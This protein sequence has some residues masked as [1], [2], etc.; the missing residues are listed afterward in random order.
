MEKLMDCSVACETLPHQKP[1]VATDQ[2][3]WQMAG[4]RIKHQLIYKESKC[5]QIPDAFRASSSN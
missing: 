3:K 5:N 2:Q 4:K 1:L